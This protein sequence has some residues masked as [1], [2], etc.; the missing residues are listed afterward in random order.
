[1][2]LFVAKKRL[3]VISQTLIDSAP[4]LANFGLLLLL[5][6][7]MFAVLGMHNFAKIDLQDVPGLDREMGYHSNFQNFPNSFFTLFRCSTGEN[8]NSIMFETTW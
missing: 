1:M 6:L 5:F 7:F 3:L 4:V 2:E 8:W